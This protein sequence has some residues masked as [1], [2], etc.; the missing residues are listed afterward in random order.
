MKL[1]ATRHE[2]RMETSGQE[3]ALLLAARDDFLLKVVG[4]I[5]NPVFVKDETFRFVLVNE[6]FCRFMGRSES[7]L[8]GYTDFDVVPAE[9]AQVFRDVDL[10]VFADGVPHENEE[11]ISN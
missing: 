3:R 9:H 1:Y 5:Q 4:G 11:T 6:A 2:H 7:E 10:K 8:L